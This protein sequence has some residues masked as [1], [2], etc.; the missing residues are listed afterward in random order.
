MPER[1]TAPE[2]DALT[3]DQAGE[4]IFKLTQSLRASPRGQTED[5]TSDDATNATATTDEPEAEIETDSRPADESADEIEATD[6]TPEDETVDEEPAP[7]K[8]GR[9]LKLSD[10]REQFVD[11]DEAYNGYLR[12][13]D[14][15]R[16]T[17]THSE[18]V[19]TFEK[20]RAT[21][22]Q[23]LEQYDA[24]L[25]QIED[26]LTVMMPQ[27]PDWDRVRAER[28]N[29]YGAL[30]TD[31]RRYQD[32]LTL[33]KSER[34][35][36]EQDRQVQKQDEVVARRKDAADRLYTLIPDWRD[37]SK[38]DADRV[39]LSSLARTYGYSDEEIVG[40]EDPRQVVV[41]RDAMLYKELLAKQA[42][43]KAAIGKTAGP[44][45]TARPGVPG[46]VARPSSKTQAAVSRLAKSGH[47]DD[48]AEAIFQS[49]RA[50]PK[51]K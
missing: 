4:E 41:L 43:A 2:S 14:Y 38:R 18:N 15:T 5:G 46:S 49:L 33:V 42:K 45:R 40:M 35:R 31:W 9:T 32:R 51:K 16:K 17:Q 34:D 29:E 27:E 8:R 28:P 10:G 24:G 23:K 37:A 11:E 30:Y 36:V 3:E 6:E 20:A 22:A 48:A 13:A 25:K 47:V 26:A 1:Y 12:Q 7:R 19:K 39:K 50:K 44:N 21:A